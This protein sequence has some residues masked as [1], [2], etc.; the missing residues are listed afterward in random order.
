M[1][2]IIN[3]TTKSGTSAL[4]L[5][6]E[7]G[8]VIMAR[9]LFERGADP[10]LADGDGKTS[11]AMAKEAKLPKDTFASANGRKQSMAPKEKKKG[12]FGRRT[13]TK[14]GDEVKL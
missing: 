12:F 11:V 7:K 1:T 13:S 14:G 10:E 4:H 8:L 5:V 3:N 9:F 2:G 6:T